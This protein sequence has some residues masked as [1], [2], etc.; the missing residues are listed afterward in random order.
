VILAKDLYHVCVT[1][2]DFFFTDE[3]LSFVTC[4]EDG[5]IRMYEYSPHGT[6]VSFPFEDDRFTP[7]SDPESKNGQHLLLRTEFH[8]Q[9]E[10]RTSALIARRGK[11]DQVI[12]HAML[13][14]GK[15]HKPHGLRRNITHV[16]SLIA[17]CIRFYRRIIDQYHAC[18]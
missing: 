9:T 3:E 12:P 5:V 17:T 11:E 8:G 7:P 2:A 15:G 4:D 13:I 16:Y 6:L 18:R 14:C 1:K 10:Y